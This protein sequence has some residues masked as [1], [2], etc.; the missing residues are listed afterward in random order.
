MSFYKELS[1]KRKA[2]QQAGDYPEW[3]T[4]GGYQMFEDKYLYQASIS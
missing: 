1:E 2:A 4:T 3:F